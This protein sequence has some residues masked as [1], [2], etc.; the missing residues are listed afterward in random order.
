MQFLTRSCRH[1]GQVL[2]VHAGAPGS[3]GGTGVFSHCGLKQVINTGIFTQSHVNITIGQEEHEVNPYIIGDSAFQLQ[4]YIMIGHGRPSAAENIAKGE[5]NR[6][7]NMSRRT[8]ECTFG[9]LKGCWQF[10]HSNMHHGDPA[11]IT[12]AVA[13]CCCIIS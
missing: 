13:V 1:S 7:I 3:C 9:R 8:V 2:Y 6:R 5:F 12:V 10:C 11:F 4:T